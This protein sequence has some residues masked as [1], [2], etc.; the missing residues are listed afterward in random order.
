[1]KRIQLFCYDYCKISFRELEDFAKNM[2]LFVETLCRLGRNTN[3]NLLSWSGVDPIA[4]VSCTST[5]DNGRLSYKIEF[6]NDEVNTLLHLLYTLVFVHLIIK[7]RVNW[8]PILQ[9]VT[10][11]GLPQR[12]G[13]RTAEYLP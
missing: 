2:S 5:D 6:V 1:M 8:F 10:R 7:L 12:T 11:K 9:L 3:A 4:A 13:N